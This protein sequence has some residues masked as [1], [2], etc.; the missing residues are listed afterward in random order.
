MKK[1][2]DHPAK[3]HTKKHSKLP[4]CSEANIAS[5]FSLFLYSVTGLGE[6]IEASFYGKRT[7]FATPSPSGTP[8]S[9]LFMCCICS[10]FNQDPRWI[11]YC[12]PFPFIP[13]K[14]VGGGARWQ[15][16]AEIHHSFYGW[17]LTS[18]ICRVLGSRNDGLF[19]QFN[20]ALWDSNFPQ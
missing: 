2:Q 7:P 14:R 10:T 5:A 12:R 11:R 15:A 3:P 17:M 13:E 4:G 9:S 18:Y 16:A 20:T 1:E 19:W 6:K 8:S